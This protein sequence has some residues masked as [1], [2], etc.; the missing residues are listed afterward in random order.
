MFKRGGPDGRSAWAG[1]GLRRSFFAG[2][3]GG[4]VGPVASY[5]SVVQLSPPPPSGHKTTNFP[6]SLCNPL[7]HIPFPFAFAGDVPSTPPVCCR[8]PLLAS[9][10]GPSRSRFPSSSSPSSL[11]G[12]PPFLT[13]FPPPSSSLFPPSPSHFS[14]F[15]IPPRRPFSNNYFRDFFPCRRRQPRNS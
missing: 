15:L 10:V 5:T 14:L 3:E 13:V 6:G 1:N 4:S 2:E 12:P 11:L 8:R 7:L 9:E